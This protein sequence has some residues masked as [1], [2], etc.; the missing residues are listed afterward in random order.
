MPRKAESSI[1]YGQHAIGWNSKVQSKKKKQEE[2]EEARRRRIT[3]GVVIRARRKSPQLE[4][5]KTNGGPQSLKIKLKGLRC[6]VVGILWKCLKK[7]KAV[8]DLLV[9]PIDEFKTSR[10]CNKCSAD[11]LYAAK[12]VKGQSVLVGKNRNTLWQRDIN[13]SKNMLSISLSLWKG[14]GRL[15]PYCRG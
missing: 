13:A 2:E 3:E 7:R 10:I 8:G 6:S 4:T 11:S 15:A 12:N 5:E 1:V 14:N 9:V